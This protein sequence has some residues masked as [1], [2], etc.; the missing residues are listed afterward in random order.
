MGKLEQHLS[1]NTPYRPAVRDQSHALRAAGGNR[2]LA[3]ELLQ[4]LQ[5]QLPSQRA[6]IVTLLE[7]GEHES[8]HELVHKL[9]GSARY[10]GAMALQAAGEML[11][12]SLKLDPVHRFAA[13]AALNRAVDQVLELR[14]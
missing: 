6:E 12:Q 9:Q 11:E 8:V 4:M 10:C 13:I 1:R 5:E 14:T 7:A 2:E 3:A